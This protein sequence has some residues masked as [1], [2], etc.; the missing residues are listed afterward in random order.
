MNIKKLLL[1]LFTRICNVFAHKEVPYVRHYNAVEPA[2]VGAS[3]VV[4]GIDPAA[5]DDYSCVFVGEAE[6][7][8]MLVINEITKVDVQF[9]KQMFGMT[10]EMLKE[11]CEL[12]KKD[13]ESGA[14]R[15][16]KI[17]VATL[18]LEMD[19]NGKVLGLAGNK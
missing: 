6:D 2:I 1:N 13:I 10:D 11:W 12:Q 16:R 14:A 18:E 8:E 15:E 19:K 5:G 4:V 17:E 7:G 9:I 3:H